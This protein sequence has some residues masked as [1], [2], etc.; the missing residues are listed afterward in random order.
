MKFSLFFVAAYA[1]F[2]SAAPGIVSTFSQERARLNESEPRRDGEDVGEGGRDGRKDG[3]QDQDR[4]R[5]DLAFNQID[6]NYL[7][8]VNELDL[9]KFQTLGRRNNLDVTIFVDLFSAQEFSLRSLLELQQLSTLLSIA[10]TGIF[11]R[12]EL[13]GLELGGLELGLIEDIASIDLAQFID[14]ALKPKITIVAQEVKNLVVAIK[15]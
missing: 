14:A 11:D 15:N 10:E 6:L 5:G 2:A 3:R 12:F 9:D 13:S 4:N 7:L 1:A 8:K